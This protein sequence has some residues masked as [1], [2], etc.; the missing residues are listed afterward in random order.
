MVDMDITQAAKS[1]MSFDACA[2]AVKGGSAAAFYLVPFCR[3]SAPQYSA[4][5]I[6]TNTLTSSGIMEFNSCH[7][8]EKGQAKLAT[9][10]QCLWDVH[11]KFSRRCHHGLRRLQTNSRAREVHFVHCHDQ[12]SG[13]RKV[14]CKLSRSTIREPAKKSVARCWP[15]ELPLQ[16]SGGAARIDQRL[17]QMEGSMHFGLCTARE[18]GPRAAFFRQALML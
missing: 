1:R 13:H 12:R 10:D 5:A 17:I 15:C 9:M 11:F 7:A 18:G 3:V 16:I 6:S 8:G 2:A 4:G 14:E